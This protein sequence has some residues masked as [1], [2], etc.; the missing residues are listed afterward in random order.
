MD[1]SYEEKPASALSDI[2]KKFQIES[3]NKHR[4]LTNGHRSKA[5]GNNSEMVREGKTENY[6]VQNGIIQDKNGYNRHKGI[7][8][9]EIIK[10]Q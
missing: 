1:E 3:S 4:K 7:K 9:I 8:N 6:I 2:H 10:H 5:S